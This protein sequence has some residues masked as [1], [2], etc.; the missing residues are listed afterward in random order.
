MRGAP[1]LRAPESVVFLGC[2]VDALTLPAAL[3][4]MV[5]AIAARQPRQVVVVNANKFYLMSRH[6]ELAAVVRGADLVLP[7]WAVVWG[8]RRLRL[9]PL[10]FVAGVSTMREFLPLAA[11]HGYRP[12]LLGAS[13]EVVTSLAQRLRL[14]WRVDVAGFHHG[15]LDT[16]A[17]EQ[18]VIDDVRRTRPDILFA[19]LG[20]PRQELWLHAHRDVLGV[21]V[22]IGVGGSFDVLAGIKP[23][24][25]AWARGNGLEWLY[26]TW[27]DPRAY[28]KRY[29]VV[30]TWFVA[31]VLRAR[32]AQSRR[33]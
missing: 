14:E 7:E 29:L 3:E 11:A 18:A 22:S 1:L 21:P 28:W 17:V 31:Q 15:Y 25:P 30:N 6:P 23:D 33:P 27:L 19:G 13:R 10:H 26:R 16:P 2:R 8:A 4:W 9:R 24:T 12:Y 5:A 20:S 32:W